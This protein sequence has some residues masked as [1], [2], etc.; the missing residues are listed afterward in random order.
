M[1]CL[2]ALVAQKYDMSCKNVINNGF[3]SFQSLRVGYAAE[4]SWSD[5]DYYY[6][7]RERHQGHAIIQLTVSGAGFFDAGGVRHVVGPGEAF[8]TEVPSDTIYGYPKDAS[9]SYQLRYLALYGELA[10]QLA[11][12]FRQQFGAVFHLAKRP[13][14]LSLFREVSERYALHTFR[15]RYEESTQLYQLFAAL[16]REAGQDAV[17]GDV[18]A[19]CHQRIQSRYREVANVNEIA[20]DAG[21]SREHLARSFQQRYGQSPA[22]M[23]RE[24]RVRA[25]RLV[26]E[27]GVDDQEAV[28]RAV[29]FSDVRTLRR[30]L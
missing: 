16:F 26:I 21:V 28:A 1:T 11:R 30:Y 8:I 14:S 29:G 12:D 6:E 7:N 13:E 10:I 23:L 25:A 5:V 18:V 15:D 4:E 2:W 24:L 17:R 20:R 22:K 19:S 27:S 3:A 9:E